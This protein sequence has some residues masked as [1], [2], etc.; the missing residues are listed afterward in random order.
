MRLAPFDLVVVPFPYS[1]R[2]AE[3]RRPALV[4]SHEDLPD[5]LGRVWLAM[6]TS[7][8]P[9]QLG[10][11]ALADSLACGLPVM[12][13]L[14]AGKLATLDRDRVLRVIGRLTPRDEEAA[15]AALRACA[16]F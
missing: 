14:R 6:I 11:A 1:D 3:R 12:S 10:D 7:N 13:T 2:L 15:R 16:G 4:V 5:L 9:A 8:V